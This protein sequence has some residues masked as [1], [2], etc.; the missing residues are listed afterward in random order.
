VVVAKVVVVVLSKR[1]RLDATLA[2]PATPVPSQHVSDQFASGE[3][4]T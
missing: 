1:E 3:R 2:F 4:V